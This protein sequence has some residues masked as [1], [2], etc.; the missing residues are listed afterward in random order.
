MYENFNQCLVET[1]TVAL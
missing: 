1:I